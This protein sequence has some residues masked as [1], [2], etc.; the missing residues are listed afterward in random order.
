MRTYPQGLAGNQLFR[1]TVLAAFLTVML[2]AAKI[3]PLFT[4]FPHM[5]P[6]FSSRCH[7][8]PFGRFLP[9]SHDFSFG[10]LPILVLLLTVPS[11]SSF[12]LNLLPSSLPSLFL[13][14][15]TPRFLHGPTG[16]FGSPPLCQ[17][18]VLRGPAQSSPRILSP[19]TTPAATPPRPGGSAQ[20]AGDGELTA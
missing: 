2:C 19:I 10:L 17:F 6:S 7:L 14:S 9:I 15:L 4:H 3:V 1:H 8:S 5:E 12:S 18:W 13:P 11:S 20:P 16:F